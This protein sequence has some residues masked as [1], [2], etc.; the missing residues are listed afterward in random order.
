MINFKFVRIHTNTTFMPLQINM[1][2]SNEY[3]QYL[4]RSENGQHIA[5]GCKYLEV[6]RLEDLVRSVEL[7]EEHDEDPVVGHLLKFCGPNIM[8]YQEYPSHNTKH[9]VQQV[10]LKK[11]CDKTTNWR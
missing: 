11:Q 4:S 9:F 10:D 6:D 7:Q 1:N 3:F 2:F 8:I 5:V